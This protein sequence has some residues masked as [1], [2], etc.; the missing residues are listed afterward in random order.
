[1]GKLIDSFDPL[2]GF[3][4]SPAAAPATTKGGGMIAELL[5]GI[6]S[7]APVIGGVTGGGSSAPRLSSAESSSN[8]TVNNSFT[9]GQFNLGGAKTTNTLFW[10]VGIVALLFLL[11]HYFKK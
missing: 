1:M 2:K 11:R 5:G 10:V 9:T 7:L 4:Q 8:G 6:S 3:N